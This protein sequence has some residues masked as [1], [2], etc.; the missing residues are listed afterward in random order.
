MISIVL[1]T[2]DLR[3]RLESRLGDAHLHVWAIGSR[4]DF[5]G[6]ADLFVLAYMT[7]PQRLRELAGLPIALVQSQTLGYD[8]I[9]D[10]LPSDIA[11]SNAID[12]HEGS[13]AELALALILAAQRGIDDAVRA[14]ERGN[15]DH[16]RRPGLAGKRVVVIGAGGVGSEIV[17]RIEPFGAEV[18]LVA[19]TARE[20][21]HAIEH[22]PLLLPHAD[23]VVIAVPL[24]DATRK[25]V[26]AGF[27]A[28]MRDGALVVNVSRGEVVD[29][30]ALVTALASGRVRA[31]LD[32]TDPEPLPEAHPLWTSPGVL[33]TPHVG[34]DTDAMDD[35]VDRLI[36]EQVRRIRTGEP[37][38][39]LVR[40]ADVG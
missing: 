17:R 36:I 38:L 40:G 2:E 39:N 16:R 5:P 34:G 1:P 26:D 4:E 15:W 13:T 33:V 30:E 6:R 24:S 12:V 8:G 37:P 10:H 18:D 11:Y 28:A 29:T 14:A 31:A 27:L 9:D 21:I 35:R 7:P 3:E 19:R 20:G 23:V 32:V 22:L 25:L